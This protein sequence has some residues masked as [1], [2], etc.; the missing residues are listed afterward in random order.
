MTA[1]DAP[2]GPQ[3]SVLRRMLRKPLTRRG[4]LWRV[5]DEYVSRPTMDGLIAGGAGGTGGGRD[6]VHAHPARRPVG[7]RRAAVSEIRVTGPDY[8]SWRATAGRER[9]EE[10]LAVVLALLSGQGDTLDGV[11]DRDG[12]LV[13]NSMGR[14]L[15][16]KAEAMA[17]Y[18]LDRA[19]AVAPVRPDVC[20][21]CSTEGE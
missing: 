13:V 3:L 7:E 6:H 1:H 10:W 19:D 21:H 16:A 17:S 8:P 12:S 9:R 4:D 20:D 18:I 15:V 14:Y 11:H 2:T 5:G